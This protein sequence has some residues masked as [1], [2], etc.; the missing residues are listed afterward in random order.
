MDAVQEILTDAI[1]VI[2]GASQALSLLSEQGK[3]CSALTALLGEVLHDCAC[4][5]SGLLDE[6]FACEQA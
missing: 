1:T 4:D 5:L 2:E 6:T 3:S